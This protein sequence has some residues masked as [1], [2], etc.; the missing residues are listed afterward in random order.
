MDGLVERIHRRRHGLGDFDLGLPDLRVL[1]GLV[2]QEITAEPDDQYHEDSQRRGQPKAPYDIKVSQPKADTATRRRVAEA[3]VAGGRNPVEDRLVWRLDAGAAIEGA[4]P[5]DSLGTVA[6]CEF[7]LAAECIR[8]I[9]GQ[10]ISAER[11]C[12]GRCGAHVD[13]RIHALSVGL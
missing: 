9:H 3:A 7:R 8:H 6:G 11:A 5:L 13:A 12:V 1:V 10:H 4:Q 2:A